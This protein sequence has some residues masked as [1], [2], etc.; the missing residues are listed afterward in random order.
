MSKKLN[1]TLTFSCGQRLSHVVGRVYE[2]GKI[3]L[4]E[5]KKKDGKSEALNRIHIEVVKNVFLFMRF[6]RN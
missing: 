6:T 2:S 3:R 5:G 4:W 1:I